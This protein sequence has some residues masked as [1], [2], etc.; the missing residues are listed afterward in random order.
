MMTRDEQLQAACYSLRE[1]QAS[2]V[3]GSGRYRRFADADALRAAGVQIPAA[4]QQAR[5]DEY[6]GPMGVGYVLTV[7][8]DGEE[9][10]VHVGPEPGR[11]F[12]WREAAG[13]E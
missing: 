13:D 3:L 11:G 5:C 1:A 8:A 2:A 4:W 7:A 10:A 9:S 12:D 6:L